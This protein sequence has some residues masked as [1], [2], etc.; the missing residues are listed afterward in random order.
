MVLIEEELYSLHENKREEV[1]K[2]RRYR[3]RITQ[4]YLA[5]LRLQNFLDKQ[6][7]HLS[8]N[9]LESVYKSTQESIH[10][11]EKKRIQKKYSD[12]QKRLNKY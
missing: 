9:D 8:Y 2:L 7:N 6:V 4:N 11:D 12:N 5:Y 3:N 10:E 1:R